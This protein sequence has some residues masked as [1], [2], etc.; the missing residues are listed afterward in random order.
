MSSSIRRAAYPAAR[1]LATAYSRRTFQSSVHVSSENVSNFK[2]MASPGPP[3]LPEKE[4][5]EWEEL[6]KHAA[7]GPE[8]IEPL[9]QVQAAQS[10]QA[11][12]VNTSS[13]SP[14]P[15][16]PDMRRGAPPEFEGEVNPKTG[17]IGGPKNEPLR[18]GAKSDWSFNGRVTDF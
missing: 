18:W 3:K 6:L 8:P 11:Q 2:F 4:Q 9:Q 15:L 10:S 1:S 5:K 14:P 16:H 12:T 7:E 17:E 13:D